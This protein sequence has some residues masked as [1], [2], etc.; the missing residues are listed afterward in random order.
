[1]IRDYKV[2]TLRDPWCSLMAVGAKRIETRG[3]TFPKKHRGPLLIHSSMAFTR[4]EEGLYVGLVDAPHRVGGSVELPAS[5]PRGCIVAIC[6]V[7]DIVK[8]AVHDART[9][10]VVSGRS[11]EKGDRITIGTEPLTD[12][13]EIDFGHYATG[14]KAIVT[15]N[16][17]RLPVP[18][19]ARGNQGLWKWRGEIEAVSTMLQEFGWSKLSERS[20]RLSRLVA[21]RAPLAVIKIEIGMLLQA[22]AAAQDAE[23]CDPIT[24]SPFRD[25][26]ARRLGLCSDCGDAEAE[27][28]NLGP[29]L[30]ERCWRASM[31]EGGA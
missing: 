6:D 5:P 3:P 1:M 17:R 11:Y 24:E 12:D 16:V 23:L 13:R 29:N 30:C 8:I 31:E 26:E 18:I 28:R 15:E 4:D 14:R 21:L 22:A 7:V 2:L 27:H 19:P 10:L 25:L 20:E 9:G